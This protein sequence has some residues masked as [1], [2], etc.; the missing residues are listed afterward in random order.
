MKR[1]LVCLALVL[2]LVS[3]VYADFGD[4]ATLGGPNSDGT[5]RWRVNSSGHLI[6]GKTSTVDI[7]TSALLVED[8]YIES[9][10][11]SDEVVIQIPLEDFTLSTTEET[12]AAP[13]TASTTPGL[14]IDNKLISLVWAD[15]E[16]DPAQTT[17]RIPADY[18]SGGIFRVVCDT[19]SA[20]GLNRWGWGFFEN[21]DGSTWDT[22]AWNGQLS[23]LGAGVGTMDVVDLLPATANAVWAAGDL[24]TLQ[25]WRDDGY[26]TPTAATG[27][28]E[29]YY[30]QF[31][32]TK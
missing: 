21:T 22:A 2:M 14:E 30:V 29:A 6:P 19:N 16:T 23:A 20:V 17:I 11:T 8:A 25:I 27:D 32:Y 5:Y 31:V 12:V 1:I 15:G 24:I 13:I 28:L 7:G 18:T 4:E 26:T 9:L 3:P 10:H